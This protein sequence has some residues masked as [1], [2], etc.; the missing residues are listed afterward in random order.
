MFTENFNQAFIEAIT[1]AG[2]QPSIED[3][4]KMLAN[5][6]KQG[7]KIYAFGTGHSHMIGQDMYGRAGGFAKIHPICEIEMTLLTHPTKSTNLER[8][9]EYANVLETLYH[10]E[11]DDVVVM[12]SNSGRNPL[13]VEYGLRLKAKGVK[14]IAITSMAHTSK[15][16]SRHESGLRL[17]EIADVVIDNFA[18]YG[19]T[20]TRIND[21]I[22]MGPISTAI[23]CHI[24]HLIIGRMVEMLVEENIEVPVFKSSNMDGAD[25]Y[26][27]VLFNKY[28]LD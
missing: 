27:K 12:I 2:N 9:S 21:N 7:H 10:V 28:Y 4:A 17:F 6:E 23:G 19:D 25:A 15:I 20:T 22:M 13:V 1:K 26:N 8:T 11:K 18:P 14:I 3:A 16:A 5:C 24:S